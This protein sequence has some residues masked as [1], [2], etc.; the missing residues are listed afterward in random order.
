MIEWDHWVLVEPPEK[1]GRVGAFP[2]M[3]IEVY[4]TGDWELYLHSPKEEK[5]WTNLR[6]NLE[7]YT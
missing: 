1:A 6:N 5:W 3:G 4:I 2:N 7:E